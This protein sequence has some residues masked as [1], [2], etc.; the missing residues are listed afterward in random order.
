MEQYLTSLQSAGHHFRQI[1][2]PKEVPTAFQQQPYFPLLSPTPVVAA[3][4]IQEVSIEVRPASINPATAEAVQPV[5][6]EQL[7]D[8]NLPDMDLLMS[9]K[10][11]ILSMP[12]AEIPNLNS[13][14][15]A[16]DLNPSERNRST[17]SSSRDSYVDSSRSS[18]RSDDSDAGFTPTTSPAPRQ[19]SKTKQKQISFLPP[20]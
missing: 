10:S 19:I 16:V 1:P 7:S 18:D 12:S 3:P 4:P 17:S 11:G 15:N 2:S 13:L 5:Q 9:S 20:S 6:H 14:L 8:N